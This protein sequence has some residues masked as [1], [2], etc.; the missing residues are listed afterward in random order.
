MIGIT[1]LMPMG[2]FFD[3]G[4]DVHLLTPCVHILRPTLAQTLSQD[5]SMNPLELGRAGII[6]YARTSHP[7]NIKT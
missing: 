2:R 3:T 5:I 6:L 1:N 7:C 4:N